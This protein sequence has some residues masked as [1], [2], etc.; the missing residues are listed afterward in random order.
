M[1]D[2][3]KTLDKKPKSIVE[4]LQQGIRSHRQ[5]VKPMLK[6]QQE[7]LAEYANSWYSD[8]PRVRRPINMIA[9]AINLMTP[10]LASR[11][12]RAMVRPRIVQFS[13]YADTLR[14]TLNHLA[15]KIQLGY[16]LRNCVVNALTYMGILK[17]GVCSGGPQIKDA[18]GYLHDAGQ[19]FCDVIYP[20]DYFWDISARKSEECDFKGNWFYVP[21]SYITDSGK[22]Q[23]YDKL[24]AAY[25]EW[26]KLGAKKLSSK[27]GLQIDTIKP[28]VRIA[29]VWIPS[30]NVI[31]TIPAEGEGTEPLRVQDY[32]GPVD[33]PY[34]ELRFSEFPESMVGVPPLYTALDLHYLINAMSRKM[35][36]QA[37]REKKVLAYQ[38]TAET[39][40]ENI[41][42]SSDG[43]SVR[44]SDI[45]AVKEIEFGGT[46]DASYKWTDW[47]MQI[48][49]EQNGNANLLGGLQAQ[50]PTL[51]QE[52]MLQS[53]STAT[54]DDWIQSVH[55]V[56][57]RVFD[58]MAFYIFTDPLMDITVSKKVGG[59]EDIPIR[60]T[61]DTREGDFWDYNF[62]VEAYS[63]TRM[64]PTLRMRRI[65]EIV[66][67]VIIPTMG[68]AQQ[69][70]DM[71]QVSQLV[72]S[73]AR[74]MDLTSS[75]IDEFYKSATVPPVTDPGPYSPLK[76]QVGDQT[77]GAAR[78]LNAIQ[79]GNR[80]G[81]ETPSPP[82][83]PANAFQGNPMG[84]YMERMGLRKDMSSGFN[85]NK[86]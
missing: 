38:G 4:A 70:G 44:V 5:T 61:A 65:M 73:I 29:E 27:Q 59:L 39:D 66:T 63:M 32:S 11:N 62:S 30:E 56:C 81:N 78:D 20:E 68:L 60:L 79:Q 33:G 19:L 47:L 48:W 41:V 72:K 12:P 6:K 14:L 55:D 43:A 10:L 49:S 80:T 24:S 42:N 36:R 74:D 23:N 46:A 75:E 15:E 67:G 85:P 9:R 35:A 28:Y 45:N 25:N 86:I 1:A 51:G 3:N 34:D 17:T 40:A 84:E 13:P 54:L 22:F 7:L 2:K 77:S 16:T 18:L 64:N 71:L 57:R 76:G 21:Y 31:V 58:K 52:Q 50:S 83:A 69:Q 26:D 53:N 82:N 37:N 8:E